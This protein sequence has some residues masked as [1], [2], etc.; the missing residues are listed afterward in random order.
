MLIYITLLFLASCPCSL[1]TALCKGKFRCLSNAAALDEEEEKPIMGARP[2]FP[3]IIP[4]PS[5][6][7]SKVHGLLYLKLLTDVFGY[8]F[9]F[10]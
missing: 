1:E 7:G 3:A 5:L 4:I 2:R 10:S 9:Y 8:C 6:P